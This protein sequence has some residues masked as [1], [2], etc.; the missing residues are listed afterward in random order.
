[1]V[2][3]AGVQIL[4]PHSPLLLL[5]RRSAFLCFAVMS[6]GCGRPFNVKTQPGL[7]PA[8]YAA[9]AAAG[10]VSIQAQAITDEDFLLE[11][12]DANL[13]AAGILPVDVMLTNRGGSAVDIKKARFEARVQGQTHKAVSAREAFKRLVSY[14]ELSAYNK[15]GY[16]KSLEAFSGYALDIGSPLGSGASRRGLLFFF[17]PSES[18][19][20]AGLTLL[21]TKLGSGGSGSSATVE[22]KLN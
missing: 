9:T 13:I 16:R 11:T 10:E 14:Y 22:L 1:M 17:V 3:E 19:R 5:A 6:L 21:L 8:N 4:S 18:A 7:P 12:F 20:G 15:S 2:R